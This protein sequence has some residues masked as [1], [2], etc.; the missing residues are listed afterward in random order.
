MMHTSQ[1]KEHMEVV[2]SDGR[3]VGTVDGVQDDTIKLAK[4]D[5]VDGAHHFVP[6]NC[7]EAVDRGTVRLSRSA[8][9]IT[10]AWTPPDAELYLDKRAEPETPVET[11]ASM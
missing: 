1:I 11:K 6:L 3:H 4:N 8:D 2:G 10:A 5:S 7:V 9:D